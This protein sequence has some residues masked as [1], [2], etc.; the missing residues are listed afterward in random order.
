MLRGYQRKLVMI[1][2]KN[3]KVF[4]SAF[5]I[6]RSASSV[7]HREMVDEANRIL[8][9]CGDSRKKGRKLWDRHIWMALGIGFLLGAISLGAV[10]LAVA[11]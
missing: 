5:F 3:S 2:T 6:M 10:W 11:L 1:R 9:E 8:A 4:E 7:T